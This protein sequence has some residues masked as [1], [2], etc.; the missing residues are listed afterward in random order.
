MNRTV[1][2]E[3]K[4]ADSVFMDGNVGVFPLID[5]DARR[6]IA[7]GIIRGLAYMHSNGVTHADMKPQNILLTDSG[8]AKITDFG[9]SVRYCLPLIDKSE[10]IESARTEPCTL[11]YRPIEH[12]N[13]ELLFS[14]EVDIWA[15]G[16]MFVEMETGC[17]PTS[18]KLSSGTEIEGR[19]KQ[20]FG[21]DGYRDLECIE[22]D[23]FKQICKAM[24]SFDP[25]ERPTANQVKEWLS[26]YK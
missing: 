26:A 23:N 3:L 4:L 22:D 1:D 19:I 10:Y 12:F 14:F 15:T 7:R 6:R 5:Y 9:I 17:L 13:N 24:Y 16:I 11:P 8:T 20:V 18:V 21:K 25:M 2:K